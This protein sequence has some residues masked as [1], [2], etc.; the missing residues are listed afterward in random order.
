MKFNLLIS[1]SG[2]KVPLLKAAQET[3]ARIGLPGDVIAGDLNEHSLSFYFTN[4]QWLMPEISDQNLDIILEGCLKRKVRIILPTRDEELLFFAKNLDSFE[5]VGISVISSGSSTVQMC[6]DKLEF[7]KILNQ[8]S[9]PAI[10][11]YTN[12]RADLG[13]FVTVKERFGAGSKGVRIGLDKLEAIK[14]SSELKNPV[15]QPTIVGE[16]FSIDIWASTD[17]INVLSSPRFRKLIVDGESKVTEIFKNIELTKISKNIVKALHLRGLAVIQGFLDHQ[18][19]VIINECNSRLGGASTATISA[20]GYILDL[21]IL[22]FLGYST[23]DLFESIKIKEI[24]QVRVPL[25]TCF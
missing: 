16:E 18:G 6:L 12:Y 17:G 25:D 9:I 15:F 24:T 21:A 7:Y 14:Y 13:N 3:L 10:K 23:K 20:G 1:S 4:R 2:N 5:Q 11:T 22:D 19:T 8:S